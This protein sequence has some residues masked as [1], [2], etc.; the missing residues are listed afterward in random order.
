MEV[1]LFRPPCVKIYVILVLHRNNC[2]GY[3]ENAPASKRL[4]LFYLPG[5]TLFGNVLIVIEGGIPKNCFWWLRVC[6]CPYVSIN[7][8]GNMGWH[9]HSD[10]PFIVILSR[11]SRGYIHLVINLNFLEKELLI[12]VIS[13]T[14]A[15]ASFD[16]LCIW[17]FICCVYYDIDL[18]AHFDLKW[19]RFSDF[20]RRIHRSEKS[21]NMPL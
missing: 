1:I 14:D 19:K 3:T 16:A 7:I 15:I 12:F 18:C 10:I 20:L 4:L 2:Y 5:H 9:S 17:D 13:H 6:W 8:T 11:W 21:S